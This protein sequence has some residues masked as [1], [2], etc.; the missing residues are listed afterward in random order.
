[1]GTAPTPRG[2]TANLLLGTQADFATPAGGNYVRTFFYSESLGEAEPFEDDPLLGTPRANNRDRTRPAPGLASL[3]GDITIPIDINH[4]P[5]WLEMLFGAGVSAGAGPYTHTFT[6]G[7]EVLPYTT[8]EIEKRAG[9]SFFQS[10]GCLASSLSFDTARAG[11]FRQATVSLVGR[12]QVRLGAS[13]GGMPAS[14][15]DRAPVAAAVGLLRIDGV[16]AANFLGGSFSY[17][18]N[19]EPDEA[20]NGSKYLSG[21]NLDGDAV[22][23]G[24]GRVRY[25]NEAYYDIMQAGDP[26]AMELEYANSANEKI[27]FSMPAVRFEKQAFAPISGPGGLQADFNWTAEQTDSEP[28]L[29]VTVTNAIEAYA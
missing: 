12:N 18:N 21:Y 20:I 14:V 23:S 3:S 26:V 9:A 16:L 17:Q 27:V 6:S 11:G 25:V 7:S 22:A 28:M 15:L 5:I 8:V 2:K 19:P 4:F 24:T 13:G 29:T 1:M 10:I